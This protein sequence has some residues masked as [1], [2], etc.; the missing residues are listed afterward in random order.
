MTQYQRE[1]L[2][3]PSKPSCNSHTHGVSADGPAERERVGL[4]SIFGTNSLTVYLYIN[5]LSMKKLG[6]MRTER[7][8]PAGSHVN[9]R[10][11]PDFW[12]R[13]INGPHS[14]KKSCW[15]AKQFRHGGRENEFPGSFSHEISLEL[16]TQE[17]IMLTIENEA[18][19]Y[20]RKHL[21]DNQ[22]VRVYFG[23]FG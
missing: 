12:C 4:L 11:I 23:G 8:T 18:S 1:S 9:E 16:E 6:R 10:A 14:F 13:S 20:F 15:P 3:C 22:A 17:Y 21:R 7:A 2:S 5:I 19:N